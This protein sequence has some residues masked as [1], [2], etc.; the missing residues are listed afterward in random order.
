MKWAGLWVCSGGRRKSWR[1]EDRDEGRLTPDCTPAV[2]SGR[3][4]ESP[5]T[6]IDFFE[7]ERTKFQI[8]VDLSWWNVSQSGKRWTERKSLDGQRMSF[9]KK[10]QAGSFEKYHWPAPITGTPVFSSFPAKLL[11]STALV[12][13]MNRRLHFYCNNSFYVKHSV[14]DMHVSSLHLTTKVLLHFK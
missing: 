10:I 11:N 13:L 2:T 6:R 9:Q 12:P 14:V 5:E 8:S 3:T 7:W 4:G 1:R